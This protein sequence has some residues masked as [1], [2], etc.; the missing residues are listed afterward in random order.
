M[1]MRSSSS[2]PG[3]SFLEKARQVLTYFRCCFEWSDDAGRLDRLLEELAELPTLYEK[4]SSPRHRHIKLLT[5]PR[6]HSLHLTH[7]P[8]ET[9]HP[10][11]GPCPPPRT[12][13]PSQRPAQGPRRRL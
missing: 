11:T 12:P 8:H 1:P 13:L 2:L 9:L 5:E 7:R 4:H 3:A 6:P 10:P